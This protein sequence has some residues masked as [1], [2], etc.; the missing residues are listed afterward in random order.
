MEK[1]VLVGLSGGVDSA[2]CCKLLKD[3]GYSVTACCC[4]MSDAH[5]A[6]V[7]GART[8]AGELDVEL[9]CVDV[10]EEFKQTVII[11]FMQSYSK[12]TTPNPCVVCNEK[13]KF[14]VLLKTAVQKGIRNIATGHY[15]KVESFN[16]IFVLEKAKD[17]KRDQSYM[18]YRLDQDVLSRLITPLGGYEKSDVRRIASDCRLSCSQASDSEDVCFIPEG[19]FTDY[20]HQCGYFGKKGN[21]ISPSGEIL[22]SHEGVEYY[23]AGQRKG[24]GLNL[25]QPAYVE[26]ILDSGDI[27]LAFSGGGYAKGVVLSDVVINEHFKEKLPGNL[28]VKIRYAAKPVDVKAC[29]ESD[30]LRLEFTCPQ[31]FPAPGQSA[32]LYSD[33]LLAAGG[34]ISDFF[35]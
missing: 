18:L 16:G 3:E 21:F 26:R 17:K 23:T 25:G 19:S 28:S 29:G 33:D 34:I 9:V 24:L 35:N 7:D 14:N 31:R 11:P 10:R 13:V 15:V 4:I 32:V 27:K 8:A 2:V 20:M 1:S 22:G 6:S 12:G 5:L 30:G